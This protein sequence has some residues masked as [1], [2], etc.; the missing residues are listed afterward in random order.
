VRNQVVEDVELSRLTKRRGFK[1]LVTP[2]T[3]VVFCRMYR[4]AAEV[5]E[6]LT[7]NLFGIT[8]YNYFAF[9]GVMFTLFTAFVLPYLAILFSGLFE[10]AALAVG[11]NLLLRAILAVR[12]KHPFWSS[13]L[14]HPVGVLFS[15]IIAANSFAQT[16]KGTVS[17]KGREISVSRQARKTVVK[18]AD[19]K[20]A[21]NVV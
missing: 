13:V 5:W 3:G 12:Y 14:L 17:W 21:E 2:G 6:G 1:T 19:A 18:H 10:L 8:G 7:K 16:L 11:M 9:A 4:S 20:S 15:I